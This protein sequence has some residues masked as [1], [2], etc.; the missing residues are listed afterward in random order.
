[1]LR[2]LYFIAIVL[3][4]QSCVWAQWN[5]G[6][7]KVSITPKEPVWMAGYAARQSPSTGVLQEIFARTLVLSDAK[8]NRL[9]IVTMDLIEIPESLRD[10][11]ME[12]LQKSH[13]FKPNE[14][15]LNVSHTHGGPM[16]AAQTV[17]DWGIDETWADKAQL[18]ADELVEKIDAMVAG[19][20]GRSKGSEVTFY[21]SRCGF[22]MNRRRPTANGFRLAPNPEGMVDHD[23]P[24]VRITMDG[25]VLGI[26]FGYACHN[27]ALGP[28]TEIHGDYAGFAAAKLEQEY[29]GSVAMF[30]AGCGGDQDPSP[31]R[32]LEDAKLNGLALA[33]AVDGALATEPVEL[34]GVLSTGQE[35]IGLPFA[36]LPSM[37]SLR[38]QASSGNGFVS[39]HAKRILNRW[40]NPGDQPADYQYPVQVCVLGGKLILVALGGEPVAEYGLRI[41]SD[42]ARSGNAVW[43]AGYSNLSNAY[44]PTRRVLREGGYEGT[45]AIIYQ[46][47]PTPFREQ[48]E[49]RIVAAVERLVQSQLSE[50]VSRP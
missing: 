48:I 22:A 31:R 23:V 21:H 26:L 4:T 32:D 38:L 2:Q 44:I 16:V 24:V 41:K 15:L 7:G 27:T 1:M 36:P 19:A 33:S 37:D 11:L 8:G 14:V 29:P 17:R 10:A 28:T 50:G 40:P 43:V 13:G 6:V 20:I 39:R 35:I 46:S 30:L 25:K 34:P 49:D 18:Y 3:W 47:L 12:R 9:A 42:L 45:E 5:A